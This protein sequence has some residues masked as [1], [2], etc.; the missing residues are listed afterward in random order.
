MGGLEALRPVIADFVDR[1]RADVMIGFHFNHVDPEVLKQRELEFSALALGGKLAYT[2]RK[3]PEAHAQHPILPGQFDRRLM[4][5]RETMADHQ[6]P[7]PVQ[8]ALLKHA[9]K[10]RS[11]ILQRPDTCAP[12]KRR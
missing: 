8:K 10:L 12:P 11:Q 2:G 3:L 9:Q 5:L 1:M 6:V 4:I 7:E